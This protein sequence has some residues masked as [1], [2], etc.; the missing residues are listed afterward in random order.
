MKADSGNDGPGNSRCAG[1]VPNKG[2]KMESAENTVMPENK[3]CNYGEKN[4][5]MQ[6]TTHNVTKEGRKGNKQIESEAACTCSIV[7]N[8]TSALCLLLLFLSLYF[9]WR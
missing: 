9:F 4:R 7:G 8:R 2:M 5:D 1:E 6:Q 3:K